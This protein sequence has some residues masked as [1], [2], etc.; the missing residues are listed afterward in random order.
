MFQLV[1]AER[2]HFPVAFCCRVLGVS[3]SGYYRWTQAARSARSQVDA[4][5]GHEIKA[6]YR[7][8]K[9]RYGSPRIHEQLHFQGVRVGRKRVARL[10]REQGLRGWI[11]RR[12]R[13]TTD[14]HH[15][16]RIAPNLLQ[17]NFTQSSPNRAWVGD[18]TY[19]PT[20]EGWLY[21][22]VLLDL[23]SRRVVGWFMSDTIDT[24]LA[25]QALHMAAKSR[26]PAPGLIH[27]TDRD[28]RYASDD[29]QA[30][31][32]SYGFVPSMS[33]KADCWD[34]AVAES[35]FATLEKELLDHA[36]LQSRAKTRRDIADY[37]DNYYNT[38]RRHSRLAY[39][40]PLEY[41][42]ALS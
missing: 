6:I 25:L 16:H 40:T 8:H 35:F 7:Q 11:R 9:G 24:E 42:M 21:L 5:L 17:R 22:A 19:V 33:R 28:C 23:Y 26:K 29:Y 2:A 39:R 15:S 37:I 3:R 27:H 32:R 13:R 30:A 4:R 14:S 10:M 36:P 38:N 12:Y 18:M 31:L 34:N 41:E 20:R 1:H